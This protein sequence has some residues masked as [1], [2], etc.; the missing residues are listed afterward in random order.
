M[1][2]VLTGNIPPQSF[3]EESNQCRVYVGDKS[4]AVADPKLANKAHG[5]DLRK[6]VQRQVQQNLN[7]K[8]K[9]T[10]QTYTGNGFRSLTINK[11]GRPIKAGPS[12]YVKR[13]RKSVFY[14]GKLSNV[15]QFKRQW[16]S[17]SGSDA[18]S[19]VFY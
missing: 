2:A 3:T 1:K 17:E 6:T 8:K 13:A 16:A 12:R 19:V 14:I 18:D 10:A 15:V 4:E 5:H 7:L 9:S 11:R